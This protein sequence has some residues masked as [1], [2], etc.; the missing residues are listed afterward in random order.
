MIASVNHSVDK[1]FDFSRSASSPTSALA[2]LQNL[3]RQ[4]TEN[5]RLVIIVKPNNY[6]KTLCNIGRK[7][8][9]K[10][11]ANLVF[12]D[13]INQAY[14]AIATPFALVR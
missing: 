2:V 11:F 3:D 6:I 14:Q 7:L 1:I 8:A 13:S 5:E 12:V 10:T 4:H 9:P